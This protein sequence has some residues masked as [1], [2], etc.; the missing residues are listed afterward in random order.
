[1]DGSVRS[2]FLCIEIGIAM[3]RNSL[4]TW[5]FSF[6][7]HLARPLN[8]HFSGDFN[9]AFT[10]K[11]ILHR[12]RFCLTVCLLSKTSI[13]RKTKLC[14]TVA[15]EQSSNGFAFDFALYFRYLF[16]WYHGKKRWWDKSTFIAFY[17][18]SL[19]TA[20]KMSLLNFALRIRLSFACQI[21]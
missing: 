2:L 10:V 13:K 15:Y 7:K 16:K 5:M 12:I 6:Y 19:T 3:E 8:G 18:P 4:F 9:F 21:N 14:S 1:M 17:L 11:P 20:K